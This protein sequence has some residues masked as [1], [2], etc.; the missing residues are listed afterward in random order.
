MDDPYLD[1]FG[2]APVEGAP[3]QPG[4]EKEWKDFLDGGGRAAM[5]SAGLQMLQPAP[6]GQTF[7]GRVGQSIGAGGEALTNAQNLYRK[8]AESDSRMES[9]DTRNDLAAEKLDMQGEKGLTSLMKRR[10][11]RPT[12]SQTPPPAGRRLPT[13]RPVPDN[14]TPGHEFNSAYGKIGRMSRSPG[15]QA[16]DPQQLRAAGLRMQAQRAIAAGA[17]PA[18]VNARLA[19]ALGS[20]ESVD[21]GPTE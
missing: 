10:G 4:L 2:S 16:M 17:D 20:V 3:V 13:E 8:D 14:T 15:V 12:D 7:A 5:L 18:L 19:K 9:A 11:R 6:A 1:P 21:N